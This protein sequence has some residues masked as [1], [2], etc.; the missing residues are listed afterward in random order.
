[1]TFPVP[2]LLTSTGVSEG[3]VLCHGKLV[4]SVSADADSGYA[5]VVDDVIDDFDPNQNTSVELSETSTA[6]PPW[7]NLLSSI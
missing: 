2:L 4:A 1:M 6:T 3:I 5:L 7:R